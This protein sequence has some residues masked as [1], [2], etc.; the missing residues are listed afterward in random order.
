MANDETVAEIAKEMNCSHEGM[1]AFEFQHYASRII[2]A[3]ERELSAEQKRCGEILR[4]QIA[5]VERAAVKVAAKD[6]EIAKLNAKCKEYERQPELMAETAREALRT[7]QE[8]DAEIAELR[9]CLKEAVDL[10]RLHLEKSNCMRRV[11]LS[12][13][14][15]KWRKALEGVK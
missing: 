11:S 13:S 8:Q 10:Y 4:D 3:H 12:V 9:E 7:L 5:E 2:A 6:A 1:I 15:D 14:I